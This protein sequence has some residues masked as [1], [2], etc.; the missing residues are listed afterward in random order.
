MQQMDNFDFGIKNGRSYKLGLDA[1]FFTGFL[2]FASV[3][4]LLLA[5]LNK[6]PSAIKYY[7]AVLLVIIIYFAG[8]IF[9]KLKND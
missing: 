4:Y 6:L 3:L 8:I 5:I 7:H 9:L 2:L 1:G